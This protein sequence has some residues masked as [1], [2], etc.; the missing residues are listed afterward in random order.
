MKNQIKD[1][2][3]HLIGNATM[4]TAW[5]ITMVLRRANPTT[6]IK[7][8]EVRDII[9]QMYSDNE[10][11]GYIRTLHDMS[12]GHSSFVHHPDGSDVED[13][14][15]NFLSQFVPQSSNLNLLVTPTQAAANQ[16]TQTIPISPIGSPI[17]NSLP[18]KPKRSRYAIDS[19]PKDKFGRIRV[20][21]SVLRAAGFAPKDSVRVVV[22]SNII[23]VTADDDAYGKMNGKGYKIDEYTNLRVHLKGKFPALTFK[24]NPSQS[25]VYITPV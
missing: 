2:I 5:D 24:M 7:H 13:Y 23:T 3:Q 14:D 10:I 12:N 9:H 18:N 11:P 20:P 1:M 6:N 25:K 19:I 4:F 8:P 21:A 16:T 22:D 17:G 15:P